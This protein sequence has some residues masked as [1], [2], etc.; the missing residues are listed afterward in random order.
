MSIP[1]PSTVL[2]ST[3]EKISKVP[4]AEYTKTATQSSDSTITFQSQDSKKN[5]AHLDSILRSEY[6]LSLFNGTR[7][8]PVISANNPYGYTPN[9]IGVDPTT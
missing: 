7:L 4:R 2:A 5:M 3:M 6:L 9:D 8:K 1:T